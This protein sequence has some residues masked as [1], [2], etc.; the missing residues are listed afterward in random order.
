MTLDDIIKL[1][2]AGY[3]KDDIF[4]LTQAVE[5]EPA[6]APAPEPEPAPA[7]PEPAPAGTD[8]LR[9]IQTQI[10]TLRQMMQINNMLSVNQEAQKPRTME[11]IFAEIINPPVKENK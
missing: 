2:N 6:P 9:D 10:E 7:N 3:T 1:A 5:P 11:D 8:P 4:K